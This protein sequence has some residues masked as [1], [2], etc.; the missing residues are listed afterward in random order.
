MMSVC[1]ILLYLVEVVEGI[2]QETPHSEN[3]LV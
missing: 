3:S 2:Y 1:I